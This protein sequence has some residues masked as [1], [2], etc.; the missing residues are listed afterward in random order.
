MNKLILPLTLLSLAAP[1]A[2]TGIA[3]AA[4][5]DRADAV[6]A[7]AGNVNAE[8]A[9]RKGIRD[10]ARVEG[11]GD[12][13]TASRIRIDCV[14]VPKVG[15]LGRCTGTFRLTRTGASADYRLTRRARTLRIAPNAIEFRVSATATRLR[16]DL[17]RSTG[18]FS[19]FLQ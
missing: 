11:A 3:V 13:A 12:G 6:V 4:P 14:A 19:G 15:D 1:A 10:F 16:G 8:A 17:P 5:A 9:M 7:P 2:T 18:S